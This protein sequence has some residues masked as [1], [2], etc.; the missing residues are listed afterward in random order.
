MKTLETSPL[1]RL[2]ATT[3]KLIYANGITATG[4]DLIARESGVSRKTIYDKFSTKEGLIAEVLC[5]RDQRWMSWFV[6]STSKFTDPRDRLLSTFDAL[7]EWFFA[8]DFNGCAFINAAGELGNT[9]DVIS[10]VSKQHKV[11]LLEYLESLAIELGVNDPEHLAVDFLLLLDGAITLAKVMGNK[12]AAR[13]GKLIAK[14]LLE[15][16]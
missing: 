11:N 10:E 14:L 7:E 3:E 2:L 9:S 4:V 1:Q 12:H 13:N 8:P 5:Q 16:A 6:L 15:N